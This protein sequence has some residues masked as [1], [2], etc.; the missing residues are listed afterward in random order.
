[1]DQ[2]G[3]VC[4]YCFA[5]VYMPRGFWQFSP[6]PACKGTDPFCTC[7]GGRNCIATP[8]E[9]IDVG[10]LEQYWQKIIKRALKNGKSLP[11][12]IAALQRRA[13]TGA[14]FVTP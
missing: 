5:G 8:R 7:C 4:Y 2:A 13:A 9:D 14:V 3:I 12:P 1:M 11:R 6:C 10:E